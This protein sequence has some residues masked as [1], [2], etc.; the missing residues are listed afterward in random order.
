MSG[1]SRRIWRSTPHPMVVPVTLGGGDLLSDPQAR[2]PY[3]PG[4]GIAG[5]NEG[6]GLLPWSWG[7]GTAHRVPRLLGRD[8][9]ARWATPR[10]AGLG[11]LV[12]RVGLVQQQRAVPQ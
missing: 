2:R 6:R 4:Y 1:T 9:V 8:R 11:H 12:R 7:R 10:D 5:P 3:M